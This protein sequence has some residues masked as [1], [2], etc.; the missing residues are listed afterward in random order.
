[1]HEDPTA[2]ETV[3]AWLYRYSETFDSLR[4]STNP[5]TAIIPIWCLADKLIMPRLK[6]DIMDEIQGIA[7]QRKMVA[8]PDDVLAVFTSAP[9]GDTR[10]GHF[11]MELF[12]WAYCTHPGRWSPSIICTNAMIAQ[13][14][15]VAA[16]FHLIHLFRICGYA[17]PRTKPRCSLHNHDLVAECDGPR[18][19]PDRPPK[20]KADS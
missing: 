12:V 19:R 4:K 2:F 16:C 18:V 9:M 1:M 20:R 13:P 8:I 10:L 6:D 15:I 17:D 5:F 7:K 11:Y 14:S 3:L